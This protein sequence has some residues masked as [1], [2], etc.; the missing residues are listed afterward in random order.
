MKDITMKYIALLRGINIGGKRIKMAQLRDVFESMDFKSVRTY[1]QSGNV[2][3]EHNSTDT[4]KISN[5]IEKKIIQTFGFSV[6]VII[7]TEGEFE[8]IINDNPFIKDANIDFDKLHVTFLHD[9][10]DKNTVLNLEVNKDKNEK[11]EVIGREIYLY[12][13]NG[14]AKTKLTNNVFE[15][16]LK[17]IATT[18]NWK[19]T[20]KI[21]E[22]SKYK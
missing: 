14:Y 19:T 11:F 21:L 7:R 3:F 16:K 10:P 22:I 8:N 12:L 2:I 6:N 20:N 18:R 5:L 17:T 4:A 13:P 1:L 15:K 9:R